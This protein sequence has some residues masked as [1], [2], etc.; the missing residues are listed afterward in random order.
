MACGVPGFVAVGTP[1]GCELD[2]GW[3]YGMGE[4]SQIWRISVSPSPATFMKV[5]VNLMASCF[6]F[7]WMRAKP[8][9][10]SLAS[11]KG[12]SVTLNAPSVL[13]MRAPSALGRQPSVARSVPDLKDSSMNF[14]ISAI[15]P[16]VGGAPSAL[17][18][19]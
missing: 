2:Q 11:V 1:R 3:D 13:R 19:L 4:A 18:G 17:A 6:D 16:W 9:T 14:P 5:L 12:P 8:P 15:S 7:A 10:I